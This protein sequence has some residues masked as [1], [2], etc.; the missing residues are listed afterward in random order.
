VCFLGLARDNYTFTFTVVQVGT[1]PV[2]KVTREM[3][4]C[5]VVS[6]IRGSS[7]HDC[8]S[9]GTWNSEV[10]ARFLKNLCT[11]TFMTEEY[12]VVENVLAFGKNLL[13]AY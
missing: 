7:P 11:P 10:A 12:C 1:N 4:F 5:T 9:S 6:N 3:K 13:P 8:H 2:C